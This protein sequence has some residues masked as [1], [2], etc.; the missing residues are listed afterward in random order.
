MV[1]SRYRVG[2][3]VEGRVTR[4][5]D[6]GAFVELEV[7][8]E[9]LLHANEMIGTPEFRPADLVYPGETLL[10]KIIHID[11]QRRRLALSARQVRREEWERWM[12][13]RQAA[14][15]AEEG[16]TA[17]QENTVSEETPT[18]DAVAEVIAPEVSTAEAGA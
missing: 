9:G 1:D 8:I 10:V 13:K 2:Q 12:A 16:E 5:L 6:F 11:S 14:Q 17:P 18:R 4:V 15:K 7:G 3:L